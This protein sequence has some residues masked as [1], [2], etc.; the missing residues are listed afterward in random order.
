MHDQSF[1]RLTLDKMEPFK[2]SVTAMGEKIKAAT[3][4]YV[5]DTDEVKKTIV[6]LP[7]SSKLKETAANANDAATKKWQSSSLSSKYQ[8][9]F[10]SSTITIRVTGLGHK[11]TLKD[12][13]ASTTTVTD[14]RTKVFEATG[15]PPRYQRLIGPQGLRINY[16]DDDDDNRDTNPTFG[17]RTLS[18]LG[19]K[20]RTKLMLLHS[21]LYASEKDSYEKLRQVERE[22]DELENSIRSSDT[23][24]DDT[25]RPGFVSEMVTRICCRLDDIDVGTS[26]AL[27]TQRKELI[28]KAE[29]LECLLS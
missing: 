3:N 8:S 17:T 9:Q 22:I 29:G 6:D 26:K 2:K 23:K 20:D 5:V 16:N 19:I 15:L 13:P 4:G 1:L 24:N 12:L 28:K 7:L 25:K 18:E 10:S 27:R 21:P 11:V 14:L